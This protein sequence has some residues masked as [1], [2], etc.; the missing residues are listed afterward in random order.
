M[1]KNYL[2][3]TLAISPMIAYVSHVF[4]LAGHIESWGRGIEKIFDSCIEND[5]PI[6]QNIILI[7]R[8]L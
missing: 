5:L 1:D 4:Y 8:I 7:L 3:K 2:Y 6:C